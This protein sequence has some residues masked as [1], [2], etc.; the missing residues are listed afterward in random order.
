MVS[1]LL[2]LLILYYIWISVNPLSEKYNKG[3]VLSLLPKNYT[4]NLQLIYQESDLHQI[5][6]YPVVLKPIICNGNNNGVKKINNITEA[7][8]HYQKY[9][10]PYIS[11]ELYHASYE[12]MILYERQP[13]QKH[14]SIIS[15]VLKE[16][17]REWKPL[18]CR[19]NNSNDPNFT[20][21]FIRNDLITPELTAKIDKISK[22]IPN[23]YAGRFDIRCSNLQELQKAQDFK[24]LELNGVMGYDGRA[25]IPSS[26]RYFYMTRWFYSRILIGI[27][28]IL[29]RQSTPFTLPIVLYHSTSRT[30]KCRDW[31]QFLSPSSL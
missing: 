16:V 17:S 30:I 11:Q 2:Y 1:K 24:I 7:R 5:T 9:P 18:R 31:E 22:N 14:G 25:C 6:K 23:F 27:Q 4:L 12:A 15:I 3:Y 28:N 8:Q 20:N 21:C 19:C 10:V 13:F 29:L 26:K